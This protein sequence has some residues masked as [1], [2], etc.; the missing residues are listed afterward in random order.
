MDVNIFPGG[1]IARFEGEVG[2]EYTQMARMASFSESSFT[3]LASPVT[4]VF[5]QARQTGTGANSETTPPECHCTPDLCRPNLYPRSFGSG[6]GFSRRRPNSDRKLETQN[7][8][9]IP[10]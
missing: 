8:D 7:A 9:G 2:L 1:Y 5:F 6:P 10:G 4:N 3:M